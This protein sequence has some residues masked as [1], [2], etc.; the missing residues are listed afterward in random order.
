[1][2]KDKNSIIKISIYFVVF[3]MFIVKVNLYDNHFGYFNDEL[4]HI[5]YIAYLEENF[6][7]QPDFNDMKLL[8]NCNLKNDSN[9][10]GFSNNVNWLGHPPLYYWTMSLM[11]GITYEDNSYIVNINKLRTNTHILACIGLLLGFILGFIK[12]KKTVP[13]LVYS[14][15]LTSIPMFSCV[16]AG[17][18]NDTMSYIVIS[19]FFFGLFRLFD[20]KRDLLTYS[21]IALGITGAGLTKVTLFIMVLIISLVVVFNFILKEKSIKVVFNKY[22][23][24][25]LVLYTPVM[26]YYVLMLIKYGSFQFSPE[27]AGFILSYIPEGERTLHGVGEYLAKYIQT[28]IMT[29]N[30]VSNH[31]TIN[32]S[33]GFF[34]ISNF[35]LN[36]ILIIP[37]IAIIFNSKNKYHKPLFVGTLIAFVITVIINFIVCYKTYL[38]RGYFGGMH[39][40]YYYCLL[41]MLALLICYQYEGQFITFLKKKTKNKIVSY[42]WDFLW[43]A[44]A[45]ILI[46][47]DFLSF[48]RINTLYY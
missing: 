37:F 26:I 36:M 48:L 17:I 6:Q 10:C 45:C 19:I 21:L 8:T 35:G 11:G 9:V 24:M 29:W 41:P 22:F 32:K 38:V 13:T 5:S 2:K 25:S 15:I 44:F 33:M 20:C 40:R 47:D 30:R 4:A 31:Y 1:M 23:F 46:Y 43:I 14:L 34:S 7:F 18:N 27:K 42:L 39:S 3:L 12:I 28:F 16:S